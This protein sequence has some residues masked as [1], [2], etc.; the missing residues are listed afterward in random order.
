MTNII[1]LSKYSNS[2]NY[3]SVYSDNL[4]KTSKLHISANA[5]GHEIHLTRFILFD[6]L[7][8]NIIDTDSIIVTLS[9]D[10]FF[11]YENIF[12]NII[13]WDIFINKNIKD[14][15]IYKVF[16]LTYYSDLRFMSPL[17]I[18]ND[19]NYNLQNF[20][21]TDLLIKYI[22]N[23][24]FTNLSL[25]YPNLLNDKFIMI[26]CR[27]NINNLDLIIKKIREY[28]NL[29]IIIYCVDNNI[30]L[31]L[32]NVY[33]INNLQVYASFL[34]NNNCDL[35]ISE[36]SGGGQLSQ[37]CYNGKILYYFNYYYLA[38]YEKLYLQYQNDA[39]LKTNLFNKWDFKTTTS[40]DRLYYKTLNELLNNIKLT[41]VTMS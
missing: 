13:S 6:L 36:W 24:N 1:I 37:Y 3:E 11:L 17:K 28:S 22:N 33:L 27:F 12:K 20:E 18:F 2:D 9:K 39:D 15:T 7:Q 29:N 41:V 35:F 16:D 10:R 38:D 32:P 30:T 14:D 26:H 40:C 21:K 8:K 34:N 4:P 25:L 31:N 23:I 19:L 5:L